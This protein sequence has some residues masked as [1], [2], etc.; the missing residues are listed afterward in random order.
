MRIGVAIA[1]RVRVLDQRRQPMAGVRV[2]ARGAGVRTAARTNGRGYARLSLRPRRA[3][4]VRI[5]VARS[6]RCVARLGVPGRAIRP[7]TG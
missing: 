4:V 7:I 6:T 1:I 2:V 5:A 3:G